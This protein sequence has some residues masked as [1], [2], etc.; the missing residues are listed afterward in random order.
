MISILRLNVLMNE[1]Q[2]ELNKY[3]DLNIEEYKQLIERK[4]FQFNFN[5]KQ[6]NLELKHL[7]EEQL[8]E[9]LLL[10]KIYEQQQSKDSVE[11]VATLPVNV[12]NRFRKTIGVVRQIIIEAQ[13][14]LMITGYAVSEYFDEIFDLII[15]KSLMGVNVSFFIDNNPRVIAYMK[16]VME[17]NDLG[18]VTLYKYKGVEQF[19]SLHAKVITADKKKAFVSSS[20]LSYNGIV[21]NLEIGTLFTGKKVDEINNLFEQLINEDC[22]IKMI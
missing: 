15:T 1:I 18:S 2:D 3:S 6:F 21:N 9:L 20:N 8:S 11:L 13:E 17:R 14:E 12:N 10:F 4:D 5:I 16:S 22:F 7:N 19:S